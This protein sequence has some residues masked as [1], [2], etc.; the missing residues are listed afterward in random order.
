MFWL[1]SDLANLAGTAHSLTGFVSAGVQVHDSS[2]SAPPSQLHGRND[3]SMDSSDLSSSK[4]D[5][6]DGAAG[7]S[8]S[9][10]DSDGESAATA[11]SRAPSRFATAADNSGLGMGGPGGATKKRGSRRR[12][13]RQALREARA[14]AAAEAMRGP[15]V[16]THGGGRGVAKAAETGVSMGGVFSVFDYFIL[17][18]LPH[19]WS[20]RCVWIASVRW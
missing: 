3:I 5:D 2:Q 20:D 9:D 8:N 19:T 6:A 13:R 17:R 18:A 7:D 16:S 1:Q 4:S 11:P 10:G 12:R 15:S 14:R